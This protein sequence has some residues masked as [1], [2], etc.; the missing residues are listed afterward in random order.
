MPRCPDPGCRDLRDPNRYA[1]SIYSS[2]VGPCL[3]VETEERIR[4]LRTT[5]R[6]R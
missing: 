2:L 6:L 1:N 5:Y 3:I 4:A